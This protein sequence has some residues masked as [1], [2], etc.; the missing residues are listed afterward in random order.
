MHSDT[1]KRRRGFSFTVII[2]LKTLFKSFINNA[3][4]Y[5]AISFV[6][7]AMHFL[8]MGPCSCDFFVMSLYIIVIT[9]ECL[10]FG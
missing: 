3:L 8:V 7:V 6:C 9:Y 1:F 4:E 5:K 2:R 10:I